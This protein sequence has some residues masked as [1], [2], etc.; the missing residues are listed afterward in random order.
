[1]ELS[2]ENGDAFFLLVVIAVGMEIGGVGRTV[3]VI[4]GA[5]IDGT[6]VRGREEVVVGVGKAMVVILADE[7]IAHLKR[8]IQHR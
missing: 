4:G 5:R 3:A 6:A 8:F 2:S 1:M 7:F